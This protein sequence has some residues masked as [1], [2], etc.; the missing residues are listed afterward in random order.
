MNFTTAHAEHPLTLSIF[1]YRDWAWGQCH[2]Y[3]WERI[4]KRFHI[5]TERAAKDGPCFAAGR[6]SAEHFKKGTEQHRPAVASCYRLGLNAKCNFVFAIDQDRERR[7][8]D[9]RDRFDEFEWCAY[10]TH[11]H[12]PENPRFRIVFPLA[13][14]V[15]P[16]DWAGF[17]G[18]AMLRFTGMDVK[19]L[20]AAFAADT[21]V[22]DVARLHF[23]P[24]HSPGEEFWVTHNPGRL[25]SPSEIERVV[26]ARPRVVIGGVDFSDVVTGLDGPAIADGKRNDALFRIACSLLGQGASQDEIDVHVHAVNLARCKPPISPKEPDDWANLCA[27]AANVT[28]R[29]GP[30]WTAP[31]IDLEGSEREMEDELKWPDGYVIN[32]GGLWLKKPTDKN[33]DRVTH[34]AFAPIQI[35]GRS[36][37]M[38]T[39][40]EAWTL[41]CKLSD[42][43]ERTITTPRKE[44][45]SH[46]DLIQLAGNSFPVNTVNAA[47]MVRFLAAFED[48]NALRLPRMQITSVPGWQRDGTFLIGNQH[49]TPTGPGTLRLVTQSDGEQ[50]LV[51]GYRTA[52]TLQAWKNAIALVKPYPRVVA[53]LLACLAAPLLKVIGAPNFILNLGGDT[54]TGKT[55]SQHVGGSI[56]GYPNE[57]DPDGVSQKWSSTVV[58]V[59]RLAAMR[60]GLPLI[61]DD[62]SSADEDR[63]WKI[64]YLV[65]DSRGKTRGAIKGIAKTVTF[66]TVCVSSG[67]H[68]LRE[69]F[70]G[71]GGAVKRILEIDGAPFGENN[72][73]LVMKIDA[74]VLANYGHAGLMLISWLLNEKGCEA[75]WANLVDRYKQARK[76]Y[77]KLAGEDGK[78]ISDYPA[79]LDVAAHVGREALGLKWLP[80]HPMEVLWKAATE[81]AQDPNDA[82]AALEFAY[83]W[84]IENQER[85]HGRSPSDFR[86]ESRLAGRW[87]T[88]WTELH[89]LSN[90][91]ETELK[92]Q[93]YDPKAIIKRWHRNG[94]LRGKDPEHVKYHIMVGSIQK[95]PVY[96]IK[97]EAL[98]E[99]GLCDLVDVTSVRGGAPFT[100]DSAPFAND[101]AHGK[102]P[103]PA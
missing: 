65:T 7:L 60:H 12:T 59:E 57:K 5:H 58:G 9:M 41:H 62:T 102:K 16:D 27:M 19:G 95:A 77:S 1:Q 34:I 85:F 84:A 96:S 83:S 29:Y 81:A 86:R 68:P 78:R 3:T 13:R 31:E 26:L 100:N 33:P 92:R 22:G 45:Q 25:L 91:L 54:T 71:K 37:D 24:A 28:N 67:E 11:S 99:L 69:F 82:K 4:L 73:S 50:Q 18:G 72:E 93:G 30:G 40:S 44:A 23:F 51:V 80:E 63:I 15:L 74:A 43:E 8:D 35:T 87:E 32:K 49:L 101:S 98:S 79:V 53:V 21:K 39:D 36:K 55:I 56:W 52:G 90:V 103:D 17:W 42:G 97:R 94:W 88:T 75:R 20:T 89:F 46:R 10:S 70:K 2:S 38:E 66:S 14:P 64:V 47:E 76:Y 48:I 61:L 6:L